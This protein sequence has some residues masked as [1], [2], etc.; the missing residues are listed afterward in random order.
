M[1]PKKRRSGRAPGI[2]AVLAASVLFLAYGC[3]DSGEPQ[4]VAGGTVGG[5]CLAD[6]DCNSYGIMD[7]LCF[8]GICSLA[9]QGDCATNPAGACP[10]GTQCLEYTQDDQTDHVCMALC[11]SEEFTCLGECDIDG[12][13]MPGP[14]DWCL[15]GF[16]AVPNP[17]V[18]PPPD[19]GYPDHEWEQ[20]TCGPDTYP[21]PPYGTRV[22]R[23][24]EDLLFL[25]ANTYALQ[26]A[27]VDGV[28]SL[29]D[30]YFRQPKVVFVFGT[31]GW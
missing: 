14:D 29:S 12:V 13:C 23:I 7:G 28:L 3:G 18:D 5:V 19:P 25:P 26:M 15:Q 22:G 27:G 11:D 6:S 17:L 4:P 30:L 8:Q 1:N 9:P 31:S 20:P 16:C 21:C 10:A 2:A 24:I